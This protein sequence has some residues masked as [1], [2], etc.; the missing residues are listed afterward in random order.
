MSRQFQPLMDEDQGQEQAAGKQDR[1]P[2]VEFFGKFDRC[3]RRLQSLETF[4]ES[5]RPH[6][7]GRTLEV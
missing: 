4:W 2:G 5:G 6:P 3:H 1:V 7:R